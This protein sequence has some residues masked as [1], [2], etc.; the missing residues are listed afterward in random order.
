MLPPP[1]ATG[2]VVRAYWAVCKRLDAA[3][4]RTLVDSG[5]KRKRREEIINGEFTRRYLGVDY[6][7][8][9]GEYLSTA[10][11][12]FVNPIGGEAL[13][14]DGDE[15]RVTVENLGEYVELVTEAW[16][17][18]AVQEQIAA[19]LEGISEVFPFQK[20]AK[21]NGSELKYMFCGNGAIEWDT[22]TLKEHLHPTANLTRESTSFR[23]LVEQLEEMSNQE[24]SDF[25][26]FVTACP[27]LPP[28]GLGALGIEVTSQ[29]TQSM[30]PTAQTCVPKLYLP[31][32]SDGVALRAG[33]IEAFK[34]ADIGG[35]HERAMP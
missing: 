4:R 32:Y 34:N 15:R 19:F 26:N 17:G 6:D 8:T 24:R 3:E 25:L 21:F 30:I 5:E 27:R 12:T 2:G 9:V 23:L 28:G 13:C 10:D 29:R 22:K 14:P 33:M 1:G 7:M 18:A 35:F 11:V 20:L 16:L 31:D